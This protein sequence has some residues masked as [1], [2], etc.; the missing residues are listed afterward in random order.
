[1]KAYSSKNQNRLILFCLAIVIVPLF[2]A[3]YL[4]LQDYPDWLYQGTVLANYHSNFEN[5]GSSFELKIYPVP[6]S[7]STLII[8][9]F[10]LFLPPILAGKMM[11][12]FWLILMPLSYLYFYR[13]FQTGD[14]ILQYAIFLFLYNIRFYQGNVSFLLSLPLLF[15]TLGYIKRR[16]NA[17]DTYH[18][19]GIS[20]IFMLL[21]ITHFIGF[22]IGLLGF[23]VILITNYKL[24]IKN[25]IKSVISIIPSFILTMIYILNQSKG[26][27]ELEFN[28]HLSLLGKISNLFSTF[29]IAF[30]FDN[31]PVSG[32]VLIKAC[33]NLIIIILICILVMNF[34][35]L[36]FK[37]RIVLNEIAILGISLILIGLFL[38]TMFFYI[39]DADTR[40]FYIG[41]FFI[42]PTIR[43]NHFIFKNNTSKIFLCAYSLI[44]LLNSF[45]IYKTGD[46]YKNIYRTAETYIKPN[47]KVLTIMG[48]FIYEDRVSKDKFRMTNRELLINRLV[49]G[50]GSLMRL[51]FY[52]YIRYNLAYPHI[53]QTSLFKSINYKIPLMIKPFPS[54][55]QIAYGINEYDYAIIVGKADIV[56]YFANILTNTGRIAYQ[57]SSLAII[58]VLR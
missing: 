27:K 9:L 4:P 2:M 43:S 53:F 58:E 7:A 55:D 3:T 32:E 11:L 5:Y 52:Y 38:P 48:N 8:A 35:K 49:P 31:E 10:S 37:R 15:F 51:P 50:V 24:K 30:N 17:L 41:A 42:L 36:M 26:P 13:S 1:M 56:T 12:S 22:V 44:I 47:K 23:A 25:Y 21:F 39:T 16:V 46:N 45:Q 57:D 54:I 20:L 28:F 29:A 40:L 18:F 34:I 33:L 6:N 14:S 19:I